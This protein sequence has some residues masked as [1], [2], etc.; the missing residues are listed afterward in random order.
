MASEA[1]KV[2]LAKKWEESQDPTEW[3]M[4]EKLD[5]VRAYWSGSAFYSRNGIK[6]EA[7]KFFFA[8]LPKEPLDGE[9]WCGRG[10]F[11]KTMSIIKKKTPNKEQQKEWEYITYLVFDAP[12]QPGGYE[13]RVKYIQKTIDESKST[14]YAAPVG[15]QKCEGVAHLKKVLK[16]ILIKGGEGIMLRKP[17]SAYEH[18]RSGVLLKCKF[19]HD[20][21]AKVTGSSPG[22]GRCASMM[23]KLFCVLPNGVTFKVGTGFSDA[24]R[25]KPPKKDAVITFKYQEL[26][27]HGNPRFPVFL[28]ERVDMTW[29]DVLSACKKRPPFSQLKRAV[30]VLKKQ[31]S[32]LF[33]TIPSRDE[34]GKKVVTTDDE[35]QDVDDE[36]DEPASVSS[37]KTASKADDGDASDGDVDGDDGG[38][39]PCRY[40][41][42]CFRTNADHLKK[43]SHPKK[44]VPLASAPALAPTGTPASAPAGKGKAAKKDKGS[45][46]EEED[47]DVE[48]G[49]VPCKFGA[50]C[51]RRSALHLA[52]Y[53]HPPKPDKDAD[54]D[55]EEAEDGGKVSEDEGADGL[56]S[57]LDRTASTSASASASAWGIDEDDAPVQS[58]T[59][60]R[61]GKAEVTEKTEKTT[62]MESTDKTD[63]KEGET[64]T[65]S[66]KEWEMMQS[67]MKKLE[68]MRDSVEEIKKKKTTATDDVAKDSE[69]PA[70]RS[71]AVLASAFRSPI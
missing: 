36:D 69:P 60:R 6:F 43:F 18:K 62:K 54:E 8:D 12:K 30:P 64:V 56:L 26:S 9:L 46:D 44:K 71:K 37:S 68:K 22:T 15:I 51:Y 16:A 40:G 67:T 38:V 13:K 24:Q 10:L 5:G 41:A 47:G 58:K 50:K 65:I 33:S 39:P 31:H 70:K 52:A 7:P 34:K 27:S 2:M 3:W 63:R 20:E 23:G 35:D 61:G 4:S 59:K 1:S 21:E 17:G 55:E 14:T 42:M 28:R 19:F 25:K 45:D 48:S 32:I 57:S 29:D 53:S 11:S 49:K 66:A